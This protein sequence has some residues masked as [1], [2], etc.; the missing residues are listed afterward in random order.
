M[1]NHPQLEAPSLNEV[2]ETKL[3]FPLALRLGHHAILSHSTHY[4]WKELG[5]FF[6]S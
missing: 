2:V 3:L 5:K 6:I 1:Q 4:P